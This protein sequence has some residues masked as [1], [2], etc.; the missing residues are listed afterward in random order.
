MNVWAFAVMLGVRKYR[1][2]SLM[3]SMGMCIGQYSTF[4]LKYGKSLKKLLFRVTKNI[5]HTPYIESIAFVFEF[6]KINYTT[7]NSLELA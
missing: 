4:F 3:P 6:K 7:E 2:I 1:V 5:I